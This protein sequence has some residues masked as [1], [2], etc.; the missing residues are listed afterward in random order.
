MAS[1]ALGRDAKINLIKRVPLFEH[2]SRRELA[3]IARIAD[4]LDLPA[5]KDLTREGEPG[6]EFLVLLEGTA[7]VR[8][9]GTKVASL[10]PGD[11]LGE[12]ALLID[13]P[14][15]ATVTTTSPARALVVTAHHFRQVLAR[16]PE[17]RVKLV[18]ALAA[19]LAVTSL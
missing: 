5:G 9:Q 13:V 16:S 12:I 18:E 7:E 10:G 11:F 19:R 3:L 6:R 17:T 15:T 14:R 2:C 1:V 4:E 8:R